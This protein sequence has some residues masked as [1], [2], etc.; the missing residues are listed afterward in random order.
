MGLEPGLA[1]WK[2]QHNPLSYG[3]TFCPSCVNA[4][5]GGLEG[6][7][8]ASPEG[9][10]AK[11]YLDLHQIFRNERPAGRPHT[12]G[13]VDQVPSTVIVIIIIIT[14]YLCCVED[15]CSIL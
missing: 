4:T 15:L 7:S 2:E 5:F 11:L 10:L 9:V 8:S 13:L 14:Y 3:G 6:L 12:N 1:E